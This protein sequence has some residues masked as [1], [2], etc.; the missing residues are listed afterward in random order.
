MGADR[1]SFVVEADAALLVG[2]TRAGLPVRG[3][4]YTLEEA[5]PVDLRGRFEE[6]MGWRNQKEGASRGWGLRHQRFL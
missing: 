3:K 6:A 1:D 4:V 5:G 2:A